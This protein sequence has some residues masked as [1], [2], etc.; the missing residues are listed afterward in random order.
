MMTNCTLISVT[1]TTMN[2][3]S[4]ITY[5][6]IIYVKNS[7]HSN[8]T[9]ITSKIMSNNSGIVL[10]KTIEDN[11]EA[12]ILSITS[13]K[14]IT[15]ASFSLQFYFIIEAQNIVLTKH[16]QQSM[17]IT[18]IYLRCLLESLCHMEYKKVQKIHST[19][20]LLTTDITL[21]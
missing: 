6:Y 1:A 15:N 18:V 10:C 2:K 20:A 11:K 16:M 17:T 8:S 12:L 13:V 14:L 21:S 4:S 5:N 19:I 3:Y 9:G 7:S